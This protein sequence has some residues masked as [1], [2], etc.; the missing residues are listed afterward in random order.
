MWSA[1][2]LF[3]SIASPAFSGEL[4]LKSAV[5]VPY[6]NGSEYPP[7]KGCSK[8][9]EMPSKS[10][11][12]VYYID[13]LKPPEHRWDEVIKDKKTAMLDLLTGIRNNTDQLFGTSVFHLINKYMPLLTSTLPDPYRRE[14]E[15]VSRAANMSLG[16]ITLFNVFYE[17]FSLCTSILAVDENGTVHH[18]RNLDF[19]L[20]LGWN[21]ATVNWLT[22]EHLKPLTIKIIFVK[23]KN[24]LFEAINFAGYIGILTGVKKGAFSIS[25]D[26]RFRLDGGYVG[27]AEWILGRRSQQWMGLLTRE[28]MEKA[29]TYK[30]AQKKLAK[31]SLIAPVY[32]ILGGSHPKEGCIIT[33]GRSNFDIISLEQSDS[34]FLVQTNY[35]HWENPPFFDNRRAPA[36]KCL[37][38]YG[39]KNVNSS[40]YSVLSTRPVLNKLTIYTALMNI[41]EGIVGAWLRYCDNP[42]WP[43]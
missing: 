36:Q 42:C 3:V 15:G 5:S 18:A 23:G 20:F 27:V 25:V 32:F 39:Q 33:R 11:V 6:R 29:S 41:R 26:E 16:E 22:T 10:G 30:D 21:P 1:L 12:P 19:G 43:W 7:F 37:H 28:V 2:C 35:D 9:T 17:F 38:N 8:I 31:S 13:L 40:L 14:L 4:I 24:R 34:W